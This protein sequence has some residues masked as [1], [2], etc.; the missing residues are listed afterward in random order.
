MVFQVPNCA[1]L[2]SKDCAHHRLRTGLWASCSWQ[3]V[4]P[5]VMVCAS[6]QH[7][8]PLQT[9]SHIWRFLERSQLVRLI[10]NQQKHVSPVA[11]C[12]KCFELLRNVIADTCSHRLPRPCR[13][14]RCFLLMSS[15]ILA[16]CD[17]PGFH[18][19]AQWLVGWWFQALWKNRPPWGNQHFKTTNQLYIPSEDSHA[20]HERKNT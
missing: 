3:K 7:D 17:F 5:W 9:V 2:T 14:S 13:S 1:S 20:T 8:L 12:G 16:H 15:V 4:A 19:L 18:S 10:E 11:S 6:T